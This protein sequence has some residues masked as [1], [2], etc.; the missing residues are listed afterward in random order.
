M[1]GTEKRQVVHGGG[2]MRE[3]GT[4][5][6]EA[7]LEGRP[8][9]QGL[10]GQARRCHGVLSAMRSLEGTRFDGAVWV[11]DSITPQSSDQ[12]GEGRSPAVAAP[13]AGGMERDGRVLCAGLSGVRVGAGERGESTGRS[14]PFLGLH[15]SLSPS[16][17]PSLL[18]LL[19]SLSPQL[20]RQHG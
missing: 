3:G 18:S 2:G 10:V 7:G 4:K 8:V 15:P 16:P 1:G 11:L 14:S 6:Q 12:L 5:G 20:C 13:Q 17:R 19:H 9:S